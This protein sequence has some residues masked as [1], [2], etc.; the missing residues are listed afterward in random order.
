MLVTIYMEIIFF[1]ICMLVFVL[2]KIRSGVVRLRQHTE[3]SIVVLLAILS[4]VLDGF[5]YL[6]NGQSFFGAAMFHD[7]LLSGYFSVT[8][9]MAFFWLRYVGFVLKIPF[10]KKWKLYVF[11]SVPMIVAVFISIASLWNGLVFE[12]N[13]FNNF[14]QGPLYN[15]YVLCCYFY[16]ML[17]FA[18]SIQRV[19]LRRYY[20]DRSLYG[21]FSCFGIFP[22]IAI[23]VRMVY[24]E[25]PAIAPSVTLALLLTFVTIQSRCISVDPLTRL[26]NRFQLTRFLTSK[27]CERQS[28]KK[29]YLFAFDICNLNTVN[30]EYGHAEG[31]NALIVFA[32]V[33]KNVCG[34]RGFFIARFGSDEFN[35]VAQL[36]DD[37]EAENLS[38]EIREALRKK[39]AR[40]PYKLVVHIAYEDNSRDV[41]TLPDF[42]AKVDRSLTKTKFS[43]A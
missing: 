26:N 18:L 9:I 15:L 23:L 1:C 19:F 17:A 16:I 39:T 41:E 3:L 32:Q 43:C 4:A 8:V 29:L 31:D 11:L 37:S 5:S 27:M 2:F 10:W 42:L 30:A 33:L 6:M 40:F 21:A 35:V 36:K 24:P 14:H 13:D 34:N 22:F 25:I 20:A 38:N 28:E 12:V 7:V